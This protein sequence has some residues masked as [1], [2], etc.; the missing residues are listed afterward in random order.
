M[1]AAQPGDVAEAG[2]IEPDDVAQIVGLGDEAVEAVVR[3]GGMR[4][5]ALLP[6]GEV[7]GAV[8]V[9][10]VTVSQW[11][12]SAHALSRSSRPTAAR[13]SR[14]SVLRSRPSLSCESMRS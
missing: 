3:R 8:V 12:P 1:H 11:R 13:N 5:S 10:A 7:D 6:V 9:H 14:K 2:Q 4:G